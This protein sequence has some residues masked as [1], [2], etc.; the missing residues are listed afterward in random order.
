MAVPDMGAAARG[1]KWFLLLEE[2]SQAWEQKRASYTPTEL[3]QSLPWGRVPSGPSKLHGLGQRRVTH[4]KITGTRFTQKSPSR[5]AADVRL[6]VTTSG[7]SCLLWEVQ[8][9]SRDHASWEVS[10]NM[11]GLALFLKKHTQLEVSGVFILLPR[12]ESNEPQ[13]A[14]RRCVFAKQGG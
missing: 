3:K 6:T 13:T 12:T 9:G 7:Q 11:A 4:E 2:A 8:G 14:H 1:R 5:E 10:P